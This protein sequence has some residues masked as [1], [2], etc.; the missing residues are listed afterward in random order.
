MATSRKLCCRQSQIRSRR[1]NARPLDVMIGQAQIQIFVVAAASSGIDCRIVGRIIGRM[2]PTAV[3][4]DNIDTI[5]GVV[6]GNTLV[7]DNLFVIS[8]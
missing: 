3:A 5:V 7:V 8:R 4:R 6:A 2:A 1:E